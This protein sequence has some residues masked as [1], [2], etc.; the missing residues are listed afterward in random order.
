[1]NKNMN[2]N[3]SKKKDKYRQSIFI[4]LIVVA[5]IAVIVIFLNSSLGRAYYYSSLQLISSSSLP[6]YKYTILLPNGA[7][8]SSSSQCASGVCGVDNTDATK[9]ICVSIGTDTLGSY[10]ASGAECSSKN[11][12]GGIGQIGTCAESTYQNLPTAQKIGG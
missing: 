7:A 8:C 11:C 6:T 4:V 9:S 12:N 1:M 10:C 2:K 3:M 5:A